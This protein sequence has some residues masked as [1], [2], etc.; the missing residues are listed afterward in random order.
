MCFILEWRTG[1]EHR[2]VAPTLSHNNN[3]GFVSGIC[4]SDKRFVIHIISVVVVA[5]ARYSASVE[6]LATVRCFLE[7][8]EMG[9]PPR[10]IRYVDVEVRSSVFPPQSASV[11]A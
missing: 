9:L 10:Y 11:Y 4:S 3:G 5:T 8:Q 2:Y 1:L 7:S 6:D